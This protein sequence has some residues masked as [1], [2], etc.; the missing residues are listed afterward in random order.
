MNKTKDISDK[1]RQN[2][3]P[4]TDNKANHNKINIGNNSMQMN[5]EVTNIRIITL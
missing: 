2:K 5:N 1:Y 3:Q 4:D